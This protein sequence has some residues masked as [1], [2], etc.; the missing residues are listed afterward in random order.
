VAKAVEPGTQS[1][2][3]STLMQ[4]DCR[5]RG[6]QRDDRKRAQNILIDFLYRTVASYLKEVPI[7]DHQLA[8]E[9]FK[10]A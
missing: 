9:I 2:D 5:F 4:R 7:H 8:I 10:G 1:A 6:Q 3:I